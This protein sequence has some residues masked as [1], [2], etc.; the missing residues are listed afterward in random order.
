MT[1]TFLPTTAV[2]AICSMNVFDW[3][4]P[5]KVRVSRHFWIFWV[6]SII[7]TACVLGIFFAWKHKLHRKVRARELAEEEEQEKR[8][9]AGEEDEDLPKHR[10]SRQGDG[11]EQPK[12]D[13]RFDGDEK[14]G[15]GYEREVQ[16]ERR[17]SSRR[18]NRRK[19]RRRSHSKRSRNRDRHSGQG[20]QRT[21]SQM[22]FRG[23]SSMV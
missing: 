23:E 1:M 18:R 3:Q 15:L 22:G 8:A 9:S 14:D 20:F 17:R 13:D 21:A 16:D 7:C 6:V 5:D 19:S 10:G 12:S 4:Q 11:N 2:A